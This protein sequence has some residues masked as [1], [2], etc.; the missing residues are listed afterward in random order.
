M[1]ALRWLT[2]ACAIVAILQACTLSS[3]PTS[4]STD[5][6]L[7]TQLEREREELAA[8]RDR[9]AELE[10]RIR[11]MQL[12]MDVKTS[13]KKN[14]KPATP[15]D[16]DAEFKAMTVFYA[17]DRQQTGQPT[18]DSFFGKD[19]AAQT[20]FGTCVVTIP[21]A[22]VKGAVERPFEF[23]VIRVPE[24]KA[25]HFTLRSVLPIPKE[26]FFSALKTAV[27]KNREK[28]ALV[29][30]HGFNNS[31]QEAAFRAAQLANDIEIDL[32]PVMYSWPSQQSPAPIAYT[33][34]E[35]MAEIAQPRFK[36][37]LED[38]VAETG[39]TTIHLV[40][41]SMGSRIVGHSLA[42]MVQEGANTTA[43]R[44][45]VLGA[46]DIN[47]TVFNEQ[48]APAFRR[49]IP[50]ISV[51]ASSTDRALELSN[52]VHASLPRLG[53]VGHPVTIPPFVDVIDATVTDS[54]VM[55][56]AYLFESRVLLSDLFALLKDNK[57]ASH[58]FGLD[59]ATGGYYKVRP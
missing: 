40:A 6:E 31:F 51:Y 35:Q 8:A 9:I 37:F 36:K 15:A 5:Q 22:H 58:R 48:I 14:G 38:L 12:L 59:R 3:A 32:V 29:F 13:P 19:I 18:P 24:S 43:F 27:A 25:K 55:G 50:K 39:A 7:R 1:S 49:G 47:V 45:L 20:S 21:K 53:Q 2:L 52:T 54:S 26:Q 57:S 23:L 34:D 16:I 10:K 11:D 4:K 28:A 33:S 42:R 30:V 17:T 46:P 44:H 56:H 41:H